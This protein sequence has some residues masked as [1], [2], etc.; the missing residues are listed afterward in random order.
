MQEIKKKTVQINIVNRFI[1]QAVVGYPLTVYGKGGQTRGYLNIKDTL[2]CVHITEKNPAKS[3]DLNIYNQIMETFT[4]NQLAK[5]TQ[6][7]GQESGY[8]VQIKNI[9]NP[10]VELEE[11]Y[12]NPSYQGLIKLGVSPN[13]LTIDTMKHM[14]RVVDRYKKEIKKNAIFRGVFW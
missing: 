7:A 12:Y 8:D 11:H 6:E 14:F 9:K 2:Q 4:V 1:V 5:L 3:G 10:R 13:Y